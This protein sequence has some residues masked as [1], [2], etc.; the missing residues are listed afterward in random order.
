MLPGSRFSY[1]VQRFER[2]RSKDW[3]LESWAGLA[4][5]ESNL[6]RTDYD[7][8]AGLWIEPHTAAALTDGKG[9]E[10]PDFHSAAFKLCLEDAFKDSLYDS[11]PF[12]T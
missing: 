2:N 4:L 1:V 10:P 6:L 8:L 12:S 5:E 9:A 7:P 11:S 3:V